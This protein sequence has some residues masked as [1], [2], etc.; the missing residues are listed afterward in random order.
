MRRLKRWQKVTIVTLLS[1][2]VLPAA[3]WLVADQVGRAA[4]RR[5]IRALEAL[6]QTVSWEDLVPPK[7]PDEENAALLYRKA[8]RFLAEEDSDTE[9]AL[10]YELGQ[11]PWGEEVQEKIRQ[12]QSQN[13]R[14]GWLSD[15]VK[16][17]ALT[18]DM[19]WEA[20]KQRLARNRKALDLVSRAAAMEKCWFPLNYR[21]GILLPLPHLAPLRATVRLLR[22]RILLRRREGD[23]PGVYEGLRTILR[24]ERATRQ[25]ELK[26]FMVGGL[27]VHI[28]LDTLKDVLADDD[29]H[30]AEW[31][32]FLGELEDLDRQD[33]FADVLQGDRI[34]GRI[35]FHA[36]PQTMASLKGS[37]SVRSATLQRILGWLER[38]IMRQNEALYLRYLTEMVEA[39]KKGPPQSFREIERVEA[40]LEA[41]PRWRSL[42]VRILA[43]GIDEMHK[44]HVCVEAKRRLA[45]IALALKLYKHETGSYPETLAPLAPGILK[46]VP[47]DPFTGKPFVYRREGEGF[48]LY[49]VGVDFTDNGG[50]EVPP[51]PDDR[52]Q[53]V[54]MVWRFKQ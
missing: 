44:A 42:L 41:Q 10:I 16:W 21:R 5:E 36:S 48:L 35:S 34:L 54:D 13:Q 23:L 27:C 40:S 52:D 4:V 6:G 1:L 7:P 17:I 14:G 28:S 43:S 2:L 31:R 29:V 49:S 15:G 32:R 39:V 45:C 11:P 19:Y 22:L 30:P 26:C 12:Y 8:F 53:G 3:A 18:E 47:L 33:L 46:S 50:N 20:V 37:F 9:E 51:D 38:P 24:L 25:P